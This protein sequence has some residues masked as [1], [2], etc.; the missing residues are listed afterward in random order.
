MIVTAVLGD[1]FF[2]ITGQI[3][4]SKYNDGDVIKII[5]T[6]GNKLFCPQKN[7]TLPSLV[8][9]TSNRCLTLKVYQ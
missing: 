8:F 4:R 1:I 9:N 5:N 6:N 3:T 2:I 7:V